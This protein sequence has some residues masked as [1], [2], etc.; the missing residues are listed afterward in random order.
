VC[1]LIYYAGAADTI[2]HSNAVISSESKYKW[3]VHASFNTACVP[4][5]SGL[6]VIGAGTVSLKAGVTFDGITFQGASEIPAVGA[7]IS[8]CI[9]K[10][11]TGAYALTVA[12]TAEMATIS[13]CQFINNAAN[14]AIRLSNATAGTYSF[15]GITF[16]GTRSANKD[17]YIAA[18]TGTVTINITNGG[19][20]P[21]YTSAGATV[22]INNAKTLT[23]TLKNSLGVAVSGVRVSIRKA[24]D[25]SEI[26]TASSD[27]NG[28]ITT[29]YAYVSDTPIKVIVRKSSTGTT[30][31]LPIA[32]NGTITTNGYDT[33][34]TLVQDTIAAA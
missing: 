8:N 30:R 32:A 3:G 16:S 12:T 2:I 11:T 34:F 25:N 24:S 21:S 10:A 13:Y 20:T 15:S 9:F 28:V 4:D 26:Y 33:E 17:L 22:V 7:T 1:G 23:I 18:T 27:V 14:Y 6:S 5:F 31:Y 19:T 29:T